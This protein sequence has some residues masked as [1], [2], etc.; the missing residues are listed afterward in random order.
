M[1]TNTFP[2]THMHTYTYAHNQLI[3]KTPHLNQRLHIDASAVFSFFYKCEPKV[4][5]KNNLIMF[6]CC[7]LKTS[8][9]GCWSVFVKVSEPRNEWEFHQ[10]GQQ[11][12]LMLIILL[13]TSRSL[14][15]FTRVHTHTHARTYTHTHSLSL[16]LSH[17]Y[18]RIH[19]H[20]QAQIHSFSADEYQCAGARVH[21]HTHTHTHTHAYQRRR[22]SV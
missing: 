9:F 17:I 4:W 20:A 5:V 10:T 22:Y 6:L 8:K 14:R 11:L 21:T 3:Y 16:S 13:L 12:R 15:K 1:Y 19:A 18:T 7:G 2:M